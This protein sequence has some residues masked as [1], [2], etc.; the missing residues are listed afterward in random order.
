M[1]CLNV[2][3]A[4]A[5]RGVARRAFRDARHGTEA[6][7]IVRHA[8]RLDDEKLSRS[9]EKATRGR[10]ASPRILRDAGIT[11]IFVSEYQRTAQTAAPLAARLGIRPPRWA[12]MISARCWP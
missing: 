9:L 8:E 10:P 5:L 3:V 7:Y 2:M 1:R 12:P 4:S 6:I 11:H